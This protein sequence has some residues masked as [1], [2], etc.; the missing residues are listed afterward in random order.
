MSQIKYIDG[1]QMKELCPNGDYT[2]YVMIDVRTAFEY[3]NEYIAGSINIPLA[4]LG[5]VPMNQFADKKVIFHCQSGM[6]TDAYEYLL[7]QL[8]TLESFCLRGGIQQW[9]NAGNPTLG[10]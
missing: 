8:V 7:E 2:G 5:S 6:R 4:E 10:R 9:K 3:N 1:Q